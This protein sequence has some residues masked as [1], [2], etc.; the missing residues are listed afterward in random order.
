[1]ADTNCGKVVKTARDDEFSIKIVD[2]ASGSAATSILSIVQEGDAIVAD[3]NDYGVPVYGRDESGNYQFL[4][5]SADGLI[6]DVRQLVH[7]GG[8]PDSMQVGDG[9]EILLIDADG[10]A[11]VS[12][13]DAQAAD[14]AAA[15]AEVVQVGGEDGA[16]N[17]Q[18]ISVN[19]DGTQNVVVADNPNK[20]CVL[21]YNTSAA[22][23]TDASVNFDYVVTDTLTFSGGYVSVASRGQYKATIGTW[24]G[25]TFTPAMTWFGDAKDTRQF[26]IDC[27]NLL[28]DGTAAIRIVATNLCS[29][30]TDLYE[31]LQGYEQ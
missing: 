14:G 3:T 22:V 31:T 26:N 21:E 1:M 2:G 6:T 24:D 8:T 16:G 13:T 12:I 7:T 30:A 28:G 29:E 19:S 11:T 15:P 25:V 20:T 4:E 18:A 23:A 5:F 10:Q 9:T 17:I 27:L